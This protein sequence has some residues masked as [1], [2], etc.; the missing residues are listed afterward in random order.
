MTTIDPQAAQK[1]ADILKKL[2]DP[3]IKVASKKL[4]DLIKTGNA[5]KGDKDNPY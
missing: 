4:D 3:K 1:A 2:Q 5:L